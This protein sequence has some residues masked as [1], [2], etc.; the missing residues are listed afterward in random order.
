MKK[1]FLLPAA[2]RILTTMKHTSIHAVPLF[3]LC[4]HLRSCACMKP[5]RA[6]SLNQSAPGALKADT[7]IPSV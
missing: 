4:S 3:I 1:W 2:A 6:A 7:L 5:V